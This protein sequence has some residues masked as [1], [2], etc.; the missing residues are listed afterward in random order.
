MWRSALLMLTILILLPNTAMAY[1]DPGT[2][3]AL[4]TAIIGG[5]V[6]IVMAVKG[7]W[8]KLKSL[9]QKDVSDKPGSDS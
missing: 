4:M 3:S 2:G 1:M 7:Y 8:Y 9:F 6:A 5:L